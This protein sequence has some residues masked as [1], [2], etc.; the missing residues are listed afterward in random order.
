MFSFS[1]R[2]TLGAL[3]PLTL[4]LAACSGQGNESDGTE[5]ATEKDSA[6]TLATMMA[7]NDALSMTSEAMSQTGL[8][9][10]LDG[11]S[12]Y[13]VM[14][15]SNAAFES[16]EGSRALFDDEAQAPVVAAML[17]EHIIPGA[18]TPETIVDAI[19]T[20]GGPVEMRTLG[21]GMLTFERDGDTIVMTAANG[22][23]ARLVDAAMVGS[24]GVLFPIDRV[25]SDLPSER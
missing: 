22:A 14:A 18:L 11:P 13:T 4:V 5:L 16:I 23:Q 8:S 2:A 19:E 25:L 17:R 12:S 6:R 15:P 20:K 10:M 21:S 3:L 7:G 9:T 1:N 24:N